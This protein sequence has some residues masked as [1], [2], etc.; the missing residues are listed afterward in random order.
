M[1]SMEAEI[2]ILF[3]VEGTE[4]VAEGGPWLT[5]FS[6]ED[7]PDSFGCTIDYTGTFDI[8]N[9]EGLLITSDPNAPFLYFAFEVN[10]TEFW[11]RTCPDGVSS[12]EWTSGW[13]VSDC[14]MDLVDGYTWGGGFGQ[15]FRYTLH[16][17][18]AP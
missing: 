17:Y 11:T 15:K 6:G 8:R 3:Y 16:L 18:T 7:V 1:V 4:I 10:E 12:D 13:W 14:G 2:M 9:V 5:P